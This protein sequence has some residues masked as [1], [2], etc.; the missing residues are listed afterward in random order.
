M[1]LQ[2]KTLL[3]FVILL[4]S[5]LVVISV[6]FSTILLASYSALEVKY[7]EKD[8]DQAVKKL[9]DEYSTLSAIVSDWGPWDDTYNFVNGNDPEYIQS[10]LLIPGFDN[11]NLNLIV[12][13]NN[14]GEVVYSGAYDLVNKVMVPVPASVLAQLDLTHPL[15]NMSDPH[16]VTAGILMLPENPMIVA[17]EPIVRS[18]FSGLPQG[19]VI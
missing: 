15:M 5:V 18:D 14:K 17:S 10:N 6:F 8:L 13:T 7:V 4:I 2:K 12:I 19:V 16:H 1:K 3:I 11:L 9:N